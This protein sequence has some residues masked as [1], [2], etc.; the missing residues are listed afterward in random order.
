[1]R[2]KVKLIFLIPILFFS[3]EKYEREKLITHS[4]EVSAECVE[5]NS[6]LIDEGESDFVKGGFIVENKNSSSDRRIISIDFTNHD[7][8]SNVVDSL[9]INQEY[10]IYHYDLYSGDTLK[11]LVDSVNTEGVNLIDSFYT[12]ALSNTSVE[13]SI[14]LKNVCSFAPQNIGCLTYYEN[15]TVSEPYYLQSNI[16]TTSYIENLN[17]YKIEFSDLVSDTTHNFIPVLVYEPENSSKEE[18]FLAPKSVR[19]STTKLITGGSLAS[20]E[21]I[22]ISVEVQSE[23]TE[24]ID[25]I[26]VVYSSVTNAPNYNSDKVFADYT[27]FSGSFKISNPQSG[28]TYYYRAFSKTN[29]KITYG[30]IKSFEKI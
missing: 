4:C 18:A 21:D 6:I 2:K 1:M 27:D 10:L 30:E 9:N 5:L 29:N 19:L 23:A 7:D 13:V 17:T 15:Q 26:G 3:C 22:T 28:I 25:E 16:V 11:V 8:Q 24:G 20:G 14:V 12:T